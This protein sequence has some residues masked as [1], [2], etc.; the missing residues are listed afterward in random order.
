ME[1]STTKG[2]YGFG[3]VV[4]SATVFEQNY[5]PKLKDAVDQGIRIHV[6]DARG[7]DRAILNYLRDMNYNYVSI[8][9]IKE[10][11]RYSSNVIK[12]LGWYVEGGYTTDDERDEAAA[13]HAV[14]IVFYVPSEKEK[15]TRFGSKYSKQ[16]ISGTEKS[17]LRFMCPGWENMKRND[18]IQWL[19][20]NIRRTD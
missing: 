4:I 19:N 5:V 2:L 6:G 17:V 13:K 16:F 18:L 10:K 14:D 12:R 20:N 9:H 1:T 8:Y 11:P 15:H 3:P 7:A